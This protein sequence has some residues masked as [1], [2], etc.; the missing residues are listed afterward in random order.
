MQIFWARKIQL[1]IAML[2]N[3]NDYSVVFLSYDEPNADANYQ[4]LLTLSPN[5]MR[6]HGIKGPDAAHKACARLSKTDRVIIVDGDNHVLPSLWKPINIKDSVD[7]DDKVISWSSFNIVN[8][9]SYGN[10]SVKCWTVHALEEMKT[11][12]IGSTIDFDLSKYLELNTIASHTIINGSA[13]QAFRAGFRDGVKLL[14]S[15]DRDF[16]KMDWRNLYRL[17]N[18]MH[19]GSDVKHGLWAIYGARLGA[20]LLLKGIVPTVVNDPDQL[21]EL[22]QKYYGLVNTN[23]VSECNK[24]GKLLNHKLITD[25]L[26]PE[27]SVQFKLNY[28]APMRSPELFLEGKLQTDIDEFYKHDRI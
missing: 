7:L 26:T 16:D 9:T 1:N 4:H 11:H 27:E 2:V 6:V 22:F 17:Y 10:G 5:A 23:L 13:Q 15:G 28:K 18:W 3:P 21:T 20:F 14:L 19:I 12:E 8:H 25:I 24:L